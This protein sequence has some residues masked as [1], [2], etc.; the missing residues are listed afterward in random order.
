MQSGDVLGDMDLEDPQTTAVGIVWE[1]DQQ[2][3][4]NV[5][6]IAPRV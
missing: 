6:P 5:A 2:R 1:S 3:P 4:G